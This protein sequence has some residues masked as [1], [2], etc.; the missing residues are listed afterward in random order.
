M[1]WNQYGELQ[2][3]MSKCVCAAIRM[4]ESNDISSL[5]LGNFLLL[6][7]LMLNIYPGLGKQKPK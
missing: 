5:L 1:K 6:A 4:L 7:E 2:N 3:N